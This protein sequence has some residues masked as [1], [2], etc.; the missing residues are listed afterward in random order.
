MTIY[1]NES[2]SPRFEL[3]KDHSD[4][5]NPSTK[6]RKITHFSEPLPVESNTVALEGDN[7]RE[8]SIVGLE[9][10]TTQFEKSRKADSENVTQMLKL[11]EDGITQKSESVMKECVSDI[12]SSFRK[13]IKLMESEIVRDVGR[14]ME[15]GLKEL[16]SSVNKLNKNLQ[17]VNE[18]L[19]GIK[20]DVRSGFESNMMES[21]EM[22]DNLSNIYEKIVSVDGNVNSSRNE[23]IK[24]N[25]DLEILK[26][27]EQ[28]QGELAVKLD[29]SVANKI[30]HFE[31]RIED[32][33]NI[34]KKSETV[35]NDYNSFC[36]SFI[37]ISVLE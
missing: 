23:I 17:L 37:D 11:M 7:H 2:D 16:S 5:G 14:K 18:T 15:K 20:E 22:T 4:H 1:Y 10:F 19:E 21:Q 12:L 24:N 6:R 8:N 33:E 28:N 35:L 34:I 27:L 29:E 25:G 31:K 26:R 32:V 13:E 3:I 36:E 30:L 9:E